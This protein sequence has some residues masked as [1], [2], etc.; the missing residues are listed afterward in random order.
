MKYKKFLILPILIVFYIF[1]IN[2]I[3]VSN[4]SI[5]STPAQKQPAAGEVIGVNEGVFV[6]VTRPYLFGLIRLPVYTSSL[7]NIAMY[8]E[9]FFCF[10]AFLTVTFI[11]TEVIMY[12][13]KNSEK[14]YKYHGK[15]NIMEERIMKKVDIQK[16]VKA[17][18]IG[19]LFGFVAFIISGDASSA[20]L[21]L[22][23]AYLEYRLKK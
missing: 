6:T 17:L 13:R 19:I 14:S 12:Y 16:L 20:P 4:I 18:G 22:L 21:G 1:L 7:G 3:V 23:V 9:F 8:H 11:I 5:S 2:F 15:S 10:I